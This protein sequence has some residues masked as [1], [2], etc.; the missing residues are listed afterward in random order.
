MTE[1]ILEAE[2]TK[3]AAIGNGRLQLERDLAETKLALAEGRSHRGIA[4]L[5][6][7][8]WLHNLEG[9]MREPSSDGKLAAEPSTGGVKN[10]SIVEPDPAPYPGDG[11][12]AEQ[13]PGGADSAQVADPTRQEPGWLPFGETP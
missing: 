1:K 13:P 3:A 4:A 7:E 11:L 5:R 6:L 12:T 10:A 2:A 9:A 8:T